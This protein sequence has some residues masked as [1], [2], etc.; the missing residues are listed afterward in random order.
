MFEFRLANH[1]TIRYSLPDPSL[2]NLIKDRI[3]DAIFI[4]S[5]R[6][7]NDR[8]LVPFFSL[9][10]QHREGIKMVDTFLFVLVMMCVGRIRLR[11]VGRNQTGKNQDGV[12]FLVHLVDDTCTS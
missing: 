12:Y 2:L 10:R 7:R 4:F 8:R 9:N 1:V 5:S 11:C 3:A 6:Y